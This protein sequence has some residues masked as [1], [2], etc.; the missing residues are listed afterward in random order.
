MPWPLSEATPAL[1]L[2]Q[3]GLSHK[4]PVAS[5][6][7]LLTL[8]LLKESVRSRFPRKTYKYL[9]HHQSG[10]CC[11]KFMNHLQGQ[12]SRITTKSHIA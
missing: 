6:L 9:S 5:N 1:F 4:S 11:F 8:N 12:Y 3:M 2:R 10:C 7:Q